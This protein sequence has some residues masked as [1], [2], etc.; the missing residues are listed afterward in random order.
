MLYERSDTGLASM[1]ES[2]VEELA[3]GGLILNISN[4]KTLTTE[5]VKNQ[6]S[7]LLVVIW[8]KCCMKGKIKNILANNYLVSDGGLTTSESDRLDEIQRA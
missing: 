7:L 8:L 3:G 5:N 6:C 4:T 1:V 2:L